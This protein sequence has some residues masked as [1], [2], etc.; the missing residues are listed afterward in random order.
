[1]NS[2]WTHWVFWSLP[3]VYTGLPSKPISVYHTGP[4]GY[5]LGTEAWPVYDHA[6]ADGW[7]KLGQQIFEY[8]DSEGVKWT[9]ID[10]TRLTKPK[11][12]GL[13][14]LWIG[15]KPKS[16]TRKCA[17]RVAAHCKEI[18]R[19][20]RITDVEVGFRES[21][22]TRLASPKLRNYVPSTDPTS[23]VCIPLTPA[24]GLQ[25]ASEQL[26]Y[27]EG[28]GGVYICEGGDSERV[29]ILTARHVVLPLMDKDE[30]YTY[31]RSSKPRRVL[32]LGRKAYQD[33]VEST[34]N[35][36]EFREGAITSHERKLKRLGKASGDPN[37]T[38]AE[39]RDRLE[40]AAQE[41]KQ[42]KAALEGFLQD[43]RTDWNPED[44]RILGHIVYSPPMSFGNT[45]EFTEDWAL[46]ELD[47]DKIDWNSFKGNVI[48]LG[49][50]RHIS[51]VSFG[52]TFGSMQAQRFRRLA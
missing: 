34:S 40:K 31:D 20:R 2:P 18:L 50:F 35:A 45:E 17:E 37:D 22:L 30:A 3:P 47:R 4:K 8:L 38:Q 42:E 11:E 29:F 1:M 16:L 19:E 27:Y 9:S 48:D 49:T 33:V 7:A 23:L 41:T 51:Q 21:V 6:I 10:V 28:T 39:K 5:H 24:L 32:L 14:F 15:V 43:V 36:I 13:I 52:L 12:S 25:I 44:Q 46:I 26:P